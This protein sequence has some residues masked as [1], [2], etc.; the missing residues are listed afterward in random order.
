[1]G[2]SSLGGGMHSTKCHSTFYDN[3]Y[4][5]SFSL[6]C[7]SHMKWKKISVK[8][9]EKT[10]EPAITANP[11][12]TVADVRRRGGTQRSLNDSQLRRW[13][14][15]DNIPVPLRVCGSYKSG[16]FSSCL[17]HGTYQSRADRLR[18]QLKAQ[19]PPV[20]RADTQNKTHASTGNASKKYLL[21][22]HQLFHIW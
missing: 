9:A 15:P 13:Q 2:I 10:F 16:W 4:Y 8:A 21:Q 6:E 7:I 22:P 19:E 3:Y 20:M 12:M 17:P 11:N 18:C 5:D 14:A 1:M